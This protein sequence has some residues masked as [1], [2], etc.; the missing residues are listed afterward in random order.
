VIGSRRLISPQR[1]ALG[2]GLAV[3]LAALPLSACKEV[4][5]ESS[6]GY[7]PASLSK[8]PG[9]K[10]D[11][12]KLVKFTKEGARRVELATARV[13]RSGKHAVI[14]YEALIYD[15]EGKT[16]VY[17]SPKPLSFL[18]MPVTVDRVVGDRV[19]LKKGPRVG[20]SVVTVGAI[21]VYGAELEIAG[22]H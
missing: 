4:E 18:R 19:L 1:R 15:D 14:P 17:T 9:V 8:A 11:D 2:L 10:G 6:E 20:T 16:L 21:E 7:V 13:T 3:I 22:S 5:S 12:V